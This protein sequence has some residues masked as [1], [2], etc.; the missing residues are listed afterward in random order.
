MLRLLDFLLTAFHLA[1]SLF[2]LTG[3]IWKKTRKFHLV[4]LCLT[5]LSWA[6]LGIWFGW[7]YCPLT[8]WHW[9][10]KRQL[11]ETN[12]PNSFIKYIADRLTGADIDSTLVD[13]VTLAALLLA[14]SAAV[15]V[16]FIAPAQRRKKQ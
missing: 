1:F 15:Y 6:L 2:N 13:G 16:N 5:I 12:L 14:I 4:T 9:D 7:G 11:G 3:W 10:V 8:E